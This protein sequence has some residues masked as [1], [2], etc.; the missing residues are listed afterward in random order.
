VNTR[1]TARSRP[2]ETRTRQQGQQEIKLAFTGEGILSGV[3]TS[4]QGRHW[5]EIGFRS[6][7]SSTPAVST[8]ARR[9]RRFRALRHTRGRTSLPPELARAFGEPRQKEATPVSL[10]HRLVDIAQVPD[11]RQSR[12]EER[13][14]KILKKRVALAGIQP[15]GRR[16]SPHSFGRYSRATHW[17]E[18][19]VP[20][21]E[22]SAL[23]RHKRIETTRRYIRLGPVKSMKRRADFKSVFRRV[24][25]EIPPE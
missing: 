16:I 25:F 13:A 23:L 6:I 12:R 1:N 9:W 17:K 2:G 19:G 5:W 11:P 15:R 14:E 4:C 8:V 3:I 24:N 22:I 18:E 10:E 7:W 21:D 20:L